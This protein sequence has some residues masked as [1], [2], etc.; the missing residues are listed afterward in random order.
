MRIIL[1]SSDVV[2]AG[3]PYDVTVKVPDLTE[4]CTATV[5]L[6]LRRAE[7]ELGEAAWSETWTHRVNVEPSEAGVGTTLQVGVEAGALAVGEYA[8]DLSVRMGR[9]GCSRP[10][11][12][13]RMPEAA[14]EPMHF[15]VYVVPYPSDPE[16]LEAQIRELDEIGFTLLSD[17]MHGLRNIAAY[18]RAARRGMRF[19]PS[20]RYWSPGA[21][22]K[23]V[24]GTPRLTLGDGTEWEDKPCL[25]HPDVRR[26]AA[27]NVERFLRTYRAHPAFEGSIYFGDDLF[28]VGKNSQG[29]V[30]LS[31]YCEYCRADFKERT[32]IAPPTE[33]A[34]RRAVVSPDQ[35]WPQ[36]MRYRTRQQYGGFIEAMEAAKDEVDPDIEMGLMHGHPD[37]PFVALAEGLY[38]PWTQPDDVVS[39]YAYPYLR[40]PAGD[41]ISHYEIGRMGNREKEL[42]MLSVC[43]ADNTVVPPGQVRQYYWNMLAAG[44]KTIA[45]FSW[46]WKRVPLAEREPEF[47]A[48]I[49]CMKDALTRCGQHKDW[50]FPTAKSWRRPKAPF[51]IL[52]SFTTEAFDIAP[53]NRGPIHS[54]RVR[55]LHRLALE[56]E[57]PVDIIS[58][59][60]VRE[61]ILDHYEAVCLHDTRVL[62]GDVAVS[63]QEFAADGGTLLVDADP[64][65]RDP[66][67]PRV[68]APLEG[69]QEMSTRTM[70][71]VLRD[72]CEPA[73]V[74]DSPDVTVRR[75]LS[76]EGEVA[77]YVFVN[78]YADRY[79]GMPYSYR[80]PEANNR[81]GDL[82][83]NEAVEA[84]VLFRDADRF[85]F[86]ASTGERVGSTDD[87][88]KL[89]LEP[90][91]GH[92]LTVLPV[93]SAALVLDGP[94]EAKQGERVEFKLQ[95]ADP[96]DRTI[97]GSFTARMTVWTPSGR[98]SRHSNH[99]GLKNG[100]ATFDLPLGANDETG[101]WRLAAEGGF[102]RRVVERPLKVTKGAPMHAPL[103]V[104][105]R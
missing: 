27:A 77:H 55:A 105:G 56:Q 85:L 93:E 95:M 71:Q 72:R 87:P 73:V 88:L 30:Q 48:R 35:A 53:E 16:A 80:D 21:G 83:R 1:P 100:M 32:G 40:A 50:I 37:D 92:V 45:Y 28:L 49:E 42:W 9:E 24:P 8:G 15:G 70:V 76:G 34:A 46:W 39:S 7:E 84:E 74:V 62:P 86:D 36:W 54:R 2:A 41:L 97:N 47:R 19:R 31:C 82:M 64:L 104:T 29:R 69:A 78:N 102:P 52:Y 44:Y 96:R 65:Y 57:L 20:L 68:K 79:W 67:H 89:S 22:N 3:K 59:D 43:E 18:D 23:D 11:S 94:E 4:P 66:W 60:E 38:A 5:E 14:A 81:R 63:V 33:P 103:H 25:N 101:T 12:F 61:G 17:H 6:R 99:F 51:A 10:I 98:R 26:R 91:W 75:F 58:E 90:S 13:F